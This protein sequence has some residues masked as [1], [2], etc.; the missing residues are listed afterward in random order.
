MEVK[1]KNF[2]FPE[3]E[4]LQKLEKRFEE[5]RKKEP[6]E[7]VK[8][9]YRQVKDLPKRTRF[10]REVY[11][12]ALERRLPEGLS[13]DQFRRELEKVPTWEDNQ[14]RLE[15]EKSDLQQSLETRKQVVVLA[16]FLRFLVGLVPR[17]SDAF[18]FFLLESRGEAWVNEEGDIVY[19]IGCCEEREVNRFSS[20]VLVHVARKGKNVIENLKKKTKIGFES[21]LNEYTT[22]IVGFEDETIG[23]MLS[24]ACPHCRRNSS[25]QLR[26]RVESWV[27]F[28][29]KFA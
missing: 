3:I 15:K 13:L 2:R 17:G 20:D 22:P 18:T 19:R 12:Q 6:S 5:E 7:A 24:K 21:A 16:P 10:Q 25:V 1:A 27:K 26:F 23:S 11:D 28:L 4:E 8:T 29:K 9:C 14:K